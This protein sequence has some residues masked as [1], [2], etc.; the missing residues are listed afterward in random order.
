[1]KEEML[2]K[3]WK[4]LGATL[5]MHEFGLTNLN[6]EKRLEFIAGSFSY[7]NVEIPLLTDIYLVSEFLHHHLVFGRVRNYCNL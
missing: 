4:P 1:M 6:N 5:N 3:C 7:N 2:K